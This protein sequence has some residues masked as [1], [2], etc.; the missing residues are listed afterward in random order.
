MDSLTQTALGAAIGQAVLD[1]EDARRG[2]VFG[3]ICGVLPDLDVL[4]RAGGEM[5][6][7]VHHRAESHSLLV[8]PLVA[9]LIGWLGYRL[10]GRGR[11]LRSWMLLAFA[12]LLTHPLLD[13]LTPY[14]TQLL[15]PLSR[16]RFAVD[17]VSIVDLFY[18]L[19]LLV[20]LWWGWRQREHPRM[21]AGVALAVSTAYLA[22][23]LWQASRALELVRPRL[24][25]AGFAA[26]EVR[27]IPTPFNVF[28][29]R[30]VARDDQGNLMLGHVS[31]WSDHVTPLRYLSRPADPAVEAVEQSEALAEFKWFAMDMVSYRIQERPDG[32]AV[33][34]VAD[35]RYG[36][37]SRPEV[38]VA[39]EARARVDRGGHVHDVTLPRPTVAIDLPAELRA[40]WSLLAGRS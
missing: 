12:A 23:G 40:W 18:T 35:Q 30:I 38:A 29:R 37:I 24:A 1:K 15:A 19:P 7:L 21:A 5:A 26:A 36:L 6:M 11:R 25:Q 22:F 16:H 28:V 4:A 17:A 34:S 9:P 20:G 39:F 8:L 2:V 13:V 33:V 31:T 27:V 3:A 14:G 32:S 10:L